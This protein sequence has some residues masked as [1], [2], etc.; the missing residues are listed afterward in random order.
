M[1]DTNLVSIIIPARNEQY[2]G[3]TVEDL[4]TKAVGEIEIIAVLD[5]YWPDPKLADNDRLILIHR[6]TPLG[7]RPAINAA[8]AIAH[9]KYLMKC[10]AHCMFALRYDQTLKDDY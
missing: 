9:G 6:G 8:A 1:T 10:D 7:M 3:K 4:L 2:L 5:G